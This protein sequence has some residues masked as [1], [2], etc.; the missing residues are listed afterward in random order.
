MEF[1]LLGPVEAYADDG[2]RLS[3]GPPKQRAVLALLLA[4]AGR[5]LSVDRLISVL[6]DDAPP[7]TALKNLQVYVYQ[8]RKI[9]GT[10]LLSSPPGYLM[11]VRPEELDLIKFSELLDVARR[12]RT[13]ERYRAA[14]SLWRGPALAD[15]AASGLLRGVVA[16]L[17]E[18]RLAARVECADVEL[19]RGGHVEVVAD[20]GEWVR[21]HPLNERLRE[22]QMIALHRAGRSAEA[23]AAYQEC[24]R[25]F[26]DELGVEPGAS[27]RRLQAA[28]LRAK[29]VV[30]EPVRQ[31]PPDV[32][33]FAGRA[34]EMTALSEQLRA[35]RVAVCVITGQAGIGKSALAV[36]MAHSVA[37][38]YPDGQLYADLAEG[39]PIGRFLR[40]LGVADEQAPGDTAAEFRSLTAD[41]RL[42]V[43][44]DN[45]SSAEQVRALVP[46]GQGSA[47]LVT[48][49][50]PLADLAGASFLRLGALP[51]R[52]ALHLL[53]GVAGRPRLEA[54]RAAAAQLVRWCGGL[55]LALRITGAR[56]VARPQWT[57]RALVGR[58]AD[59]RRRLDELRLGD[60]AV[61]T[62]FAVSY[63]ELGNSLAA[64]TFRLLGLVDGPDVSVASAVALVDDPDVEDVLVELADVHLVEEPEPGRFHLHDLLRLF[65]RERCRAEESSVERTK[66]L[67]RLHEHL[68]TELDDGPDDAWLEVERLNLLAAVRQ[69]EPATAIAFAQAL[70]WYFRRRS[71][72][73]E[74]AALN[75]IA[76]SAARASGDVRAEVLALKEL[77]AAC[78]RGRRV[79][80]AM[81]HWTS[82]L[83]LSRELGDRSL[84]AFMLNNLGIVHWH[85]RDLG[86]A[87]GCLESS[88]ALRVELDDEPG[89][90]KVLTNLGLVRAAGGDLTGAVDCY[91]RALHTFRQVG[92][93][94]GELHALAN[95]ANAQR[96]GGEARLA[97]ASVEA[98]LVLARE[99]GDRQTEASLLLDLGKVHELAGLSPV[100]AYSASLD[101]C[102]GIG[103]RWGEQQA[104][105][106]LN[107][108]SAG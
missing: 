84:E 9:V 41:R 31:L 35:D 40:A 25:L 30:G 28:I 69:A 13:P 6:W 49:R 15:L 20:L 79:D 32:V 54:D 8:L 72:V 70:S 55:P 37:R 48:S 36:R 98:A 61:R 75:E 100:E 102:R 63:A 4:Q 18:L 82:A 96:D 104:V 108:F 60:L 90:A 17:D 73:V 29:P 12:E 80:E 62:A 94:S 11:S 78:E 74:W 2:S 105:D 23:L 14:L 57:L 91:E 19:E 77:G 83:A 33:T 68:L 95:I 66:A 76:L 47:V 22:Q 92:D 59:E 5:V 50:R 10:R 26:D 99:L 3:V 7:K 58:L 46:T 81:E 44:L 24:R 39:D 1:R 88:L 107:N 45:V 65:A 53:A 16:Q 52:E 43:V 71:E 106:H 97:Q 27:L 85:R 56:L 64:R 21:D 42:L 38:D 51:I 89:A 34:A 87:L 103:F 93:R 101:L 67:R 86:A